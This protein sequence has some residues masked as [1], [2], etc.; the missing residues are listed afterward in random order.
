MNLNELEIYLHHINVFEKKQRDTGISINDFPTSLGTSYSTYV[1]PVHNI[2]RFPKEAFFT[3]NQKIFVNQHNRF[4]PMIEHLHDFI[5]MTYVYAGSCTQVIHGE[6]VILPQG[7]LC[8]LDKDVPHSIYPLGEE[9]ILI[10]ILINEE[11][12]S[13]LFLFQ[14]QNE[15]S[16]ISNFLA[17]AF[18]KQ[19]SHDQYMIFDTNLS[20]HF[21]QQIQLFLAEYWSYQNKRET[22][23]D[24]YMQLIL[25]ELIRIFRTNNLSMHRDATFDYGKI[26]T[27][28]DEN[29]Q[30]L[31]L[32]DLSKVFGYN[33]NYLSN[34]LKKYIG[35]SF[36]E[37][38]LEK[39]LLIASDLLRNTNFSI[40]T[41]ASEAGFNNTSYFF[42]QFK[43]YYHCTP[44]EFRKKS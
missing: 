36:Q 42:R 25:M 27:F 2:I 4:A 5:E 32:Q 43:K 22:F 44:K 9:D 35:K 40:D 21:H 20:E 33:S 6:T 30:N 8:V 1:D 11:T 41:I 26:L 37:I 19:A 3:D 13:S 18:N 14:L 31:K 16:L 23:L 39:R 17:D 12:F 24:H 29:H 15:A 38:L 28:I 34:M 10:N 7:S